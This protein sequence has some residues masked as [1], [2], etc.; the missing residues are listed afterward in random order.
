M[1]EAYW[2][3]KGVVPLIKYVTLCKFVADNFGNFN[4]KGL[5]NLLKQICKFGV[6]VCKKLVMSSLS[7]EDC[8]DKI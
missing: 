1:N 4:Y 8:M 2:R 6:R 5:H 7:R 3:A